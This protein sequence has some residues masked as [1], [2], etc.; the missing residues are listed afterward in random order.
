MKIVFALVFGVAGIIGLTLLAL[1]AILRAALPWFVLGAGIA[2]AL[3]F[4]RG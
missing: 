4:L 1:A 2:A 3:M